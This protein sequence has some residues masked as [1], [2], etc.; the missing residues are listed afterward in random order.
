MAKV[1]I[2]S[3]LSGAAV[4]GLTSPTYTLATDVFPGTNP[5]IQWAVTSLGGTQTTVRTSTV[6]N[7]FTIAFWRGAT[8]YPAP[9]ANPVTGVVPRAKVMNKHGAIA[10]IGV[11]PLSGQAPEL[12]MMR[13]T[14]EVPPGADTAD[15]QQIRAAVSAFFGALNQQA[16]NFADQIISGLAPGA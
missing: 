4:A 11:V 15:P 3:P 10:R 16:S 14:V 6:G 7:P 12:M 13:L 1:N 2:S 5:G 9:I 8:M